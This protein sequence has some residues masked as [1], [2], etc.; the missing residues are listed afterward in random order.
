MTTRLDVIRGARPRR[1]AAR[2]SPLGWGPLDDFLF[3]WSIGGNQYAQPIRQTYTPGEG[4]QIPTSFL[5]YAQVHAG[6]GPFFACLAVRSLAFA[7]ARYQ[8]RRYENGRPGDLFGD[9]TLSLVERPWAGGTTGELNVRLEQDV[10]LAGNSYWTPHNGELRRLRPD[11]VSILRTS[12]DDVDA[13]EVDDL[14]TTLAGYLYRPPGAKRGQLLM[15]EQVIH[16]SPHPDPTASWRGM[17]WVTPV[18]REIGADNA[19][20]VHK[21]K[22]FENGATPNMVVKLDPAA[23]RELVEDLREEIGEKHE[24]A[25]NA[26]KTMVLG[27]G[28]DV[29]VV[30]NSFEQINFKAT[31]GAGETRIAAAAGVPPVLVGLSE[32]LQSATYSNYGQA[33]RRFADLTLRPLWRIAA[34]SIETVLRAP[35]GAHL[36]YDDRD[37]AFLRE[38]MKDVAEIRRQRALTIQAY[39]QAG[40]T[41]ESAVAAVVGENESLLVHT[42]LYP[43]TM[44]PPGTEKPG[45]PT[46]DLDDE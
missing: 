27:G 6:N 12:H 44:I 24:G 42:G 26:Y 22:F 5:G 25:W 40:Y 33:R 43:T 36:Y 3:Q 13:E 15:P 46:V 14:N 23:K 34:A 35:A 41:P 4:E 9:Q 7:E 30:G 38:D 18:L 21:A 31:Q 37:I 29:T 11:W 17:S 19:A 45:A 32:G 10:A 20:T 28:A 16:Y 39:V 8:W 2:N 1:Q